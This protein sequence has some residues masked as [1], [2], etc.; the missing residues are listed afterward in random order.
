MSRLAGSTIEEKLKLNHVIEGECWR[1]TGAHVPNGYGQIQA[2]GRPRGVHRLAYEAW[3]GPIPDG[4][5]V[6]HLCRVRDC[7]NPAHLEAV[8]HLENLRR[9]RTIVARQIAKTECP[10][11]HPYD[12]G[13][14]IKRS[15]GVRICRACHNARSAAYKRKK[16]A[17][18]AQ[19]RAIARQING[20][21]S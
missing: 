11:G 14:T 3:V 1:W 15:R 19:R 16:R 8:T 6:D 5:E 10:Q 18:A 12:E 13:N 2:N 20:G 21:A 4:L 17:L 7:I 9:G